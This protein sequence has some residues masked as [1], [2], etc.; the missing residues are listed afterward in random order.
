MQEEHRDVPVRL[1]DNSHQEMVDILAATRKK[2][3][4]PENGFCAEA[5]I[6]HFDSLLRF[7]HD[8]ELGQLLNI[9]F[10]RGRSLLE[11]GNEVG[12]IEQFGEMMEHKSLMTPQMQYHL[13]SNMAVAYMRLGERNNCLNNH[14]ADACIMPIKGKGIHVDQNGSRNAIHIFTSILEAFPEDYDILW[15]LNLAYMT[16]G[17]YPQSVPPAYLIPGLD[18]K[19]DYPVSPFIDIAGIAGLGI[20]NMAG[21]VIVEDFDNDGYLDIVTSA[22]GINDPMHFFKNNGDGT[23]TDRSEESG[24][25]VLTGG[26]NIVHAD[27]NNDGFMD[28]FVLRGGWQGQGGNGEQPNSLIR[29]NGDG[30]FTDVTTVAGLLSFMPTQTANWNDFNGD[31]WIDLFIGNET[32]DP[33]KPYPCELYINNQNGTFTNVAKELGLGINRFVK[34]VTSGDFD[35]DGWLDIFIA[36]Y[37]FG[38]P[39]SFYAAKEALNAHDSR[40]GKMYLYR[41]NK[42]GTFT[43]VASQMGLDKVAFAMG[44]NFGDID[45][46]GWLDFYLGTGNPNYQSLVPNKLFKNIAGKKF[47]DVTTSSRTGHL[48]K[49]HGIAFADLDNDGDQD[50]YID[51]GGAFQGDHYPNAFYMNPGQNQNN[52]ICIKLEGTTSNKAAIG[53]RIEVRFKEN[54][55]QRSVFRDVNAGGCFGCSPF[56]SE[57][58]IGK[59]SAIDEII[60]RWPATQEI[61]RLTN[62][63]PNQFI[64][65]VEGEQGF[66]AL[67]IKKLDF[68]NKTLSAPMCAP[69]NIIS[70]L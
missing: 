16:L 33:R 1:V 8:L 61:Q 21:G 3:Y 58:G 32:T 65:I 23:F 52:W 10:M 25:S 2:M 40:E 35:N 14:S 47:A 4:N 68:K 67:D 39:L 20:D 30:T 56:R 11:Y 38:R 15:L 66:V 53:A 41:S 28:I 37:D 51:M 43:E 64:S 46:D 49:G 60:I 55:I 27:Y 9:K 12:A 29:N 36:D 62:L 45:N 13:F 50:I 17:E 19:S 7:G 5:K 69:E 44:N 59:A 70:S 48:Q 6:A 42:N 24:L 57:I 18:A 63:Q 54:G 31:G 34:G 26:L 22:W